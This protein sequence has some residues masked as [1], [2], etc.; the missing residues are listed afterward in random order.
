MGSTPYTSINFYVDSCFGRPWNGPYARRRKCGYRLDHRRY[1]NGTVSPRCFMIWSMLPSIN[2]RYLLTKRRDCLNHR[3]R[4]RTVPSTHRYILSVL[5][6]RNTIPPIRYRS[7]L[8]HR[9]HK[10]RTVPPPIHFKLWSVSIG[11]ILES[12]FYTTIL[13]PKT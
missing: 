4:K 8:E 13:L 2:G 7:S 3:C 12:I 10:N 1:K 5:R 11:W 6:S 9:R